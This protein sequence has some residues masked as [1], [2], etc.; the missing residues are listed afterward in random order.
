[1]S[2]SRCTQC[3]AFLDPSAPWACKYCGAVQAM[4][5]GC[6]P[7]TE[8]R[9][10]AL[11]RERLTGAAS[12]SIHPLVPPKKALGVR[13]SH[14]YLAPDECILAL[15]D[16][17]V[18]G[19]ATDGFFVTTRRF[20]FKN[21][22]ESAQF[23]EWA[24]I[25]PDSIYV[26][27]TKLVVGAAQID[28]LYSS[29]EPGLWAWAAALETI[30]TSARPQRASAASS[31]VGG[32][33]AGPNPWDAVASAWPPPPPVYPNDVV[34]RLP[35]R[36]YDG[37]T[38]C[39][40]VDVHPSGSIVMVCSEATVDLRYASNS[41]RL[42]AFQAPDL[43]LA[44]RF[45]RDGHRLAVGGFDRKVTLYEVQS[46]RILGATPEMEDS[47]D[48][49]VWL[50]DSGRFAAASHLGDLWIV[51][52]VTAEPAL[53]VLGSSADHAGLG[54]LC[55]SADGGLLFVSVGTRLGAFDTATGKIAWRFDDALTNPSRLA[56]SPR[57][58]V[59]VAAGYDGVALFD[60]RTGQPGA[61]FPLGQ[62]RG[63]SWA[64]GGGGLFGKPEVCELSWSPRPR[65]SPS[66]DMVAVQDPTG[67]LV[68]LDATHWTLHPTPRDHGCAWIEDL[69]W[70][71][72]GNHLLLGTSD[73]AFAIWSVR[74]LVRVAHAFS[75]CA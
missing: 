10:L 30:A 75:M 31:A 46:G 18:F 61:R 54:G 43:V 20:G 16:G 11:V 72:D 73:G 5:E 6:I 9:I 21:Q 42:R 25:D 65:F 70:F 4:S 67:N 2:D 17:T 50:G 29:D 33:A 66:G 14:P 58:D 48:E 34:E 28:T 36:P 32:P 51:D 53:R 3:G 71:G 49:I 37:H 55:A 13:K 41:A 47:I 7:L 57:G 39:S 38:S 27:G 62:A 40:V 12:T 24:H 56:V 69:A 22:L 15:Y 52:G 44:A 19:S 64:E 68:F 1:M 26:D 8:E 35:R 45:S 60:A 23:F 59:L 63:V 74:P